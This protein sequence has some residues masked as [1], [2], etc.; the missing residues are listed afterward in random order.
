M[1][2]DNNSIRAENRNTYFIFCMDIDAWILRPNKKNDPLICNT[3]GGDD[4]VI[5]EN[6]KEVEKMYSESEFASK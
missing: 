5:P 3:V 1:D 6:E 2:F 4:M